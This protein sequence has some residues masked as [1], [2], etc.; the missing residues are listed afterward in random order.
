MKNRIYSCGLE[1]CAR[2]RRRKVE[3]AGSLAPRPIKPNP[4]PA[5]CSPAM[6]QT[7]EEK[8]PAVNRP[9]W[10]KFALYGLPN[11]GSAL[12]S[13]FLL[14]WVAAL[15]VLYGFRDLRFSAGAAASRPHF[16]GI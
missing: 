1:A 2:G 11:R 9:W 7:A 6:S 13:M 12:A 16:C 10:V 5:S 3:G 14:V 4:S 8:P 15:L